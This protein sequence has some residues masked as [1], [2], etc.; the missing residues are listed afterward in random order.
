MLEFHYKDQ[1]HSSKKCKSKHQRVPDHVHETK[2][3]FSTD[4][5]GV[6]STAAATVPSLTEQ[7]S[8]PLALASNAAESVWSSGTIQ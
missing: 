2:E 4:F 3:Q 8:L 5:G 1:D 7:A 6:K